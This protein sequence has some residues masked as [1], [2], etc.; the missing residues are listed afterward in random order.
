M[1]IS[2]EQLQEMVNV[3]SKLPKEIK[4][5][6]KKLAETTSRQDI[7]ST[8]N[9][10]VI[11]FF[12][13]L[14]KI[15]DKVNEKA[16]TKENYGAESYKM[17]FEQALTFGAHLPIDNISSRLLLVADKIY[18]NDEQ[19]FLNFELKESVDIQ[20]DK[21]NNNKS[22]KFDIFDSDKFKELW[23]QLKPSYREKLF[24][25]LI[26]LT[27]YAHAYVFKLLIK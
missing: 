10:Y 15:I 17:V 3:L 8:F 7:I 26:L 18:N 4:L 6:N 24:E 22:Y 5:H 14:I 19:F 11:D 23:K 25:K 9:Q 2:E 20:L 27:T 13:L 1:A 16:N 12:D 21:N